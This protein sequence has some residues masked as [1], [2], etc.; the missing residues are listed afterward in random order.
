[1]RI[2]CPNCAWA[3]DG[4][5]HWECEGCHTMF[6]TFATHARCPQCPRS[7]LE[8]QCIKCGKWSQHEDWYDGFWDH[9]LSDAKQL[10]FIEALPM[11][12]PS[13]Q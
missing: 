12:P 2:R 7:W 5:A 11:A 3:P 8:T 4:R 9:L 6:D 13:G 10:I 1:M